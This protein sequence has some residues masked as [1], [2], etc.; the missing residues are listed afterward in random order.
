M[1]LARYTEP[2]EALLIPLRK[3]VLDGASPST[4]HVT[5]VR[6]AVDKLHKDALRDIN[7]RSSQ[8]ARHRGFLH[9]QERIALLERLA[10]FMCDVR[11]ELNSFNSSS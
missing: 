4:S 9:E 7:I 8:G 11:V 2:I 6:K 10:L 5:R 1:N 3:C